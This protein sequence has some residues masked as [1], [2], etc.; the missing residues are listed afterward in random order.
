M[1][2]IKTSKENFFLQLRLIMLTMF[3]KFVKRFIWKIK[4]ILKDKI[5]ENKK[6][7]EDVFI[8]SFSITP[9][10]LNS[11]LKYE[12]I[13]EWDSVGHMG[14]IAAL[15]ET[16]DIVLDMDDIIDFSSYEYGIEI[17]KKYNIK[18]WN[19]ILFF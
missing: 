1:I 16:F 17:L 19:K 8:E 7:Y 18:F 2:I 15:E 13:P 9:D 3:T 10:K 12:S 5:L 11:E 4:I 14:M 6:K